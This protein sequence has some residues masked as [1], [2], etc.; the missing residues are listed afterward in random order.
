MDSG[1]ELF[2]EAREVREKL[3]L[4][5]GHDRLLAKIDAMLALRSLHGGQVISLQNWL[6]EAREYLK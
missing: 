6:K 3:Y 1:N 5:G 4:L 2:H